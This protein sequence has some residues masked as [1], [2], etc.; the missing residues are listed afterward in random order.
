[1][2]L[3]FIA[4]P[5][6]RRPRVRRL[7][8]FTVAAMIAA[9]GGGCRDAV[10]LDPDATPVDVSVGVSASATTVGEGG[11]VTFTITVTNA[12]ETSAVASLIVEDSMTAGLAYSSHT[13]LF[14][15]YTRATRRW[16]VGTLPPNQSVS[17]SIL[18]TTRAGTVGQTHGLG[19]RIISTGAPDPD[20]TNNRSGV[21]LVVSAPAAPVTFSSTWSAA[22][23]NSRNALNDGG[24]W[25][26]MIECS[27]GIFNVMSVVAGSSVGWTMTPNVLRLTQLG[28][29]QCGNIERTQNTIAASTTHWGRFYFRNDETANPHFHPV[30]YNCCGAIQIVP[31]SRFGS[32]AGVKIGVGGYLDANGTANAYPF[33]IWFP[34]ESPGSGSSRLSNATWYRYEWQIVYISARVYRIYPRIYDMSGNLLYDYTRFYQNDN[35][36]GAA[37]KSLQ[38]WYE[39]DNRSFGVSDVQLARNFGFGNEGPGGSTNSGGSWYIANFSMSTSGWIGQ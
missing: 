34:G 2:L 29:T 1:M 36:S 28:S 37:S 14:G 8:F 24:I 25:D 18:A 7:A 16:D 21:S 35:G 9:V 31:W 20:T 39:V 10:V 13:V 17:L 6:S 27:G 3:D 15:T 26:R 19:A 32:T 22:T 12:S 4:E 38:T 5:A 11:P 30:T 33:S 23:G